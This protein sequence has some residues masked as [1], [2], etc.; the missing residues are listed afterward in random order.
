MGRETICTVDGLHFNSIYNTRR[1]AVYES[2]LATKCEWTRARRTHSSQPQVVERYYGT[3]AQIDRY[4]SCRQD[5][6]NLEKK[7]ETKDWSFRVNMTLLG[8]CIVDGWLLFTGGNGWRDHMCQRGFY[9][10][11]ATQLIENC[12]SQVSLRVR[13]PSLEPMDFEQPTSSCVGIH[14]T[15]TTEK[16]R[17]TGGLITSYALQ[18]TCHGANI[19]IFHTSSGRNC[20]VRH[21]ADIQEC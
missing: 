10:I 18:R 11:L 3:C 21:L 20:F 14:L 16:R 2:P 1:N 15:P 5:G 19:W 12:Y 6:L 4:N 9:E 8:I 17:C 7:L 13:L